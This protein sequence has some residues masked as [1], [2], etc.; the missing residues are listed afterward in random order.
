MFGYAR[1]RSFSTNAIVLDK[2]EALLQFDDGTAPATAV[3]ILFGKFVRNVPVDNTDFLERS[4]QFEGEIPN[5][6][7][8]AST[9][10]H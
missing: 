7:P 5:L 6:F 2:V 9:G 1:I 4:F 8:L 3:D 10:Y